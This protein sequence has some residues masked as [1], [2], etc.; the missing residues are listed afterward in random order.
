MNDKMKNNVVLGV[1]L[2]VVLLVVVVLFTWKG[3]DRIVPSYSGLGSPEIL[4]YLRVHG[5]F[6]QGGGIRAT[7]SVNSAETLL[8]T[9]FDEENVIDYTSNVSDVTLTLPASTTVP[10]SE[11]VGSVRTLYLRNATTTA[12]ID[13][14]IAGG[15]GTLL[16]VASSTN[17][18]GT[19]IIY[20]DTDGGNHARLDFLRKANSDI[21]VLMTVFKD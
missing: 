5:V 6:T 18:A 17:Q 1:V 16:K 20:G 4:T 11:K 21:E 14:T 9:D 10:L 19:Q 7:S 13:I 2:A 12:A 15:T 8:G 3:E